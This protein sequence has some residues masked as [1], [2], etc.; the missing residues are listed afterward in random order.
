MKYDLTDMIVSSIVMD[1]RICLG[2]VRE[3][4]VVPALVQLLSTMD[5]ARRRQQ[6]AAPKRA[7]FGVVVGGKARSVDVVYANF[8]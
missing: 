6:K 8:Q 4:L 7:L 3:T 5:E 2:G 1:S